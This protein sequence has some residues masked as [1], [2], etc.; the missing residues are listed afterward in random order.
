[1]IVLLEVHVP[2]IVQCLAFQ[3]PLKWRYP[4]IFG[5]YGKGSD[6]KSWS[7]SDDCENNSR[8]ALRI[9]SLASI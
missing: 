7:D 6:D 8:D 2:Y 9:V 5:P 3:S 4:K 1:M